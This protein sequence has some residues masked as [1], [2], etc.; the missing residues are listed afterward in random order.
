[1]NSNWYSNDGCYPPFQFDNSE[2]Q[3]GGFETMSGFDKCINIFDKIII[4][5]MDKG[6][7]VSDTYARHREIN[8]RQQQNNELLMVVKQQ[9]EQ[10]LQLSQYLNAVPPQQT[11][12]YLPQP[13]QIAL[14]PQSTQSQPA[15]EA[16]HVVAEST[17]PPIITGVLSEPCY[18]FM[19]DNGVELVPEHKP[20]KPKK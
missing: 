7:K 19:G 15:F 2:Q 1:M 9:Q 18:H 14:L 4:P 5:L 12:Q 10:I 13:A 16:E 17:E 6:S 3:S 8:I 20:K 11:V